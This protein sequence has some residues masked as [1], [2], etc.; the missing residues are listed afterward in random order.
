[1]ARDLGASLEAKVVLSISDPQL[2]ARVSALNSAAN[3]VDELRTVF[4]VSQ[5]CGGREMC[6]TCVLCVT[7]AT[8]KCVVRLPPHQHVGLVPQH[9]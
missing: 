6:V 8:Y 3:G 4:I 9:Q 5:V 2:A 7:C 1:M